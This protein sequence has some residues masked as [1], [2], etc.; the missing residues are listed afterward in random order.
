MVPNSCAL[1][2]LELGNIHG[3]NQPSFARHLTYLAYVRTFS[4]RRVQKTPGLALL[5]FYWRGFGFESYLVPGFFSF[6]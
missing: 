2:S 5:D 1:A 3:D 6:Y 4:M